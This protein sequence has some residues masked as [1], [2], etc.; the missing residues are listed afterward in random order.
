[1]SVSYDNFI[2]I[3]EGLF[4]QEFCQRAI[5]Y[6]EDMR[7]SGFVYTR[8]QLNDATKLQKDDESV[9]SHDEDIISL[10]YTSNLQQEFNSIFWGEAYKNYVDNY[11]ILNNS[12]KHSSYALKIQKTAL[13][14]GYHVWHY[15]SSRRETCNRLMAWILYLNDV[16]E[17]GE[18]EFLYLH[19]RIKPKAG[20]LLIWPA[21]FTH[22]H[23]GNPPLSGAKYIITGWI[24]F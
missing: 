3:Y 1:M 20:T 21:A 5:K 2:G 4:S 11:Q 15:E 24:E 9:F 6:F 14:G 8:Q 22:T 18:T 7:S 16:E 12:D 19:K 23:R 17:G 13:G 10:S